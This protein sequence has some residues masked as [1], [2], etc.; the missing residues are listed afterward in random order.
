[1]ELGTLV[2]C[3]ILEPNRL[4]SKIAMPPT[5][6]LASNGH[7]R[8]AAYEKWRDE[9]HGKIIV[10]AE[11]FQLVD[12][13]RIAANNHP[14]VEFFREHGKYTEQPIR[15][16]DPLTQVECKGI[17]DLVCDN[18]FVIDIKTCQNVDDMDRT[19]AN[20]GYHLQ[21]AF[22]LDGCTSHYGERF[23]KFVIVACETN[24]PYRV[25]SRLL[26]DEAIM[27]GHMEID[28]LLAEFKRRMESGDWSEEA[29]KNLVAL[30]LPRWAVTGS[31]V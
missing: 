10:N 11:E 22:Y 6:V 17:P 7:R 30:S 12:T 18:G 31:M 28:R 8:G 20:F 15:W 9:Q 19:M 4:A 21:A 25:H 24:P 13:L 23:E 1:M 3:A 16:Q 27:V 5:E 14:A 29:E 2:H 26:D